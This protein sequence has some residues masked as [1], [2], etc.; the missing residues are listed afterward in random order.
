MVTMNILTSSL[1]DYT[2]NLLLFVIFVLFV[3]NLFNIVD[4]NIYLPT[5]CHTL[6]IVFALFVKHQ[7]SCNNSAIHRWRQHS[8][9]K[10]LPHKIE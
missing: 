6:F 8:V 2:D 4:N 10:T 1:L 7:E 5:C 3:I 9:E